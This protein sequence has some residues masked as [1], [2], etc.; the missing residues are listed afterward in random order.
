MIPKLWW[1]V[2]RSCGI[3]AW[4]LLTL[5]VLWGLAV[6][7]RLL[8]KKAPPAW[9]LDLHRFLGGLSVTFVALHLVGLW[10]DTYVHFGPTQLFVPFAS[11][12]H[13]G[14]V[15]WGV[16]GFYLLIAIEISSL[17]MRHIP[18]RVWL[19]VHRTSFVLYA[20]STF[21]ALSAG[22]DAKALRPFAISSAVVA[23]GF[24]VFLWSVRVLSP[25]GAAR[26]REHAA[27]A[28]RATAPRASTAVP[29]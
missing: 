16:V 8:G 27:R 21:H 25:R 28:P 3:V 11:R 26:A 23:T 10:A 17:A 1:F 15:A 14:A 7:T 9:L 19:Q 4:A 6:S 29:D 20:F 2:A 5:S 12:W 22:T 18:R 13:P 24:V